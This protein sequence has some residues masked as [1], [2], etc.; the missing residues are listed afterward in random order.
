MLG[1]KSVDLYENHIEFTIFFI[2]KSP[3]LKRRQKYKNLCI[4]AARQK[5]LI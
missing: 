1:E 5:Q 2:K 4:F 3:F